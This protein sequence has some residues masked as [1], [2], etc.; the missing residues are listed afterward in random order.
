MHQMVGRTD[1]SSLNWAALHIPDD[2]SLIPTLTLVAK[3]ERETA[4]T[5]S[6]VGPN[7]SITGPVYL[8]NSVSLMAKRV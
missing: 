3:S 4:S 1:T 8:N 2:Y 5:I 7:T 6:Q